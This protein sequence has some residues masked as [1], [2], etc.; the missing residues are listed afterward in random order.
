M[1]QVRL[2]MKESKLMIQ[3]LGKCVVQMSLSVP[4]TYRL[5]LENFV[6]FL[7]NIIM[8]PPPSRQWAVIGH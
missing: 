8:T 7:N 2:D 1:R 6:F 3:L 5:F 4:G